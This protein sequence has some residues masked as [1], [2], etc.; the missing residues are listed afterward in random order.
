L[1]VISYIEDEFD[2][3]RGGDYDKLRVAHCDDAQ[4]AH[5][6]I[7]DLGS[8]GNGTT[9]IAR[10]RDGFPVISYRYA[11]NW[12][13][14]ADIK[15]AHCLDVA[16]TRASIAT[17]DSVGKVGVLSALAI[18]SDGFPVIAYQDDTNGNLKFAH[19]HTLSCGVTHITATDGHGRTANEANPA[20]TWPRGAPFALQLSIDAGAIGAVIPQA[21]LSIGMVTSSGASW[22]GPAG[23]WGP[24]R[25]PVYGG[26]LPTVPVLPLIDLGDSS[27]LSAEAGLRVT[28]A[29]RSSLCGTP[30]PA[31][32]WL[33]QNAL[34]DAAA[35]VDARVKGH[36]TRGESFTLESLTTSR[37][38]PTAARGALLQQLRGQ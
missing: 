7:T 30:E 23:T 20:V 21:A 4:C 22:L 8:G 37:R 32:K 5:V 17:V 24:T 27:V 16:C 18:G 13:L 2:V 14:D 9:S 1:P 11:V 12:N 10:G 6:T 25:S 31:Q 29:S 36:V 34:R 15:V 33:V 3:V 38:N 26:P 19:C 35:D 28:L